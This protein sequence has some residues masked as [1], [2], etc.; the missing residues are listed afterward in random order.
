MPNRLLPGSEQLKASQS[1]SPHPR[2]SR[3]IAVRP[4]NNNGVILAISPPPGVA[5]KNMLPLIHQNTMSVGTSMDSE[6]LSLPP[7]TLE[8]ATMSRAVYSVS[9][10]F[11]NDKFYLRDP[12]V[13]PSSKH[14]FDSNDDKSLAAG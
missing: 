4:M 12:E 9:D 7:S 10:E 5:G 8:Y 2:S 14:Q 3:Y 11:K 1:Q 13:N 6:E